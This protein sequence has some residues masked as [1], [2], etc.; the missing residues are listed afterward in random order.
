VNPIGSLPLEKFIG[1]CLVM[2][3]KGDSEPNPIPNVKILSP[4]LKAFC[5]S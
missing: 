3:D 1:E 4:S 2:D 5:S